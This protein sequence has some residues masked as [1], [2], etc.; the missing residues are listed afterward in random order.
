MTRLSEF[1]RP[2]YQRGHVAH[3]GFL[4][5]I[6]ESQPSGNTVSAHAVFKTSSFTNGDIGRT[7]VVAFGGGGSLY[8]R[9]AFGIRGSDHSDVASRNKLTFT[10]VSSTGVA[11]L[12]LV[13]NVIVTDN[14]YHSICGSYNSATGAFTFLLDMLP[15]DD[16]GWSNR[17][18]TT[19]VLGTAAN[20]FILVGRDTSS[21][22]FLGEIG[23]VGVRNNHYISDW[24]PF[25][26]ANG[27]PKQLD[28]TTWAEWG[29]QPGVFAPDGDLENN[30]GTLGAFRR[31]GAIGP[32]FENRVLRGTKDMP[33]DRGGVVLA[34]AN[35]RYA[36]P[37]VYGNWFP[38]I[39]APGITVEA[40]DTTVDANGFSYKT[41]SYTYVFRATGLPS[42]AGTVRLYQCVCRFENVALSSG[43]GPIL[44]FN[45]QDSSNYWGA[46]VTWNGGNWQLD[47][48]Q[49]IA[50]VYTSRGIAGMTAVNYPTHFIV[51][52]YDAGDNL[53]AFV[54][55]YEV[56]VS[57]NDSGA[58]VQYT[59]VNRPLKTAT[60]VAFRNNTDTLTHS[61]LR[62]LLVM[63]I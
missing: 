42:K 28:T 63:D 9:L 12:T 37:L 22:A 2:W 1:T 23:F 49:V 13:T 52:V 24:S 16:T 19:G 26:Y 58:W 50:G 27:Q 51:S 62:S 25:F 4:G 18:V 41:G 59:V 53:N 21:S 6:K 11:L 61:R 43:W 36:M 17:V 33:Q 40:I 30:L 39:L 38:Q 57:T 3:N 54:S 44:I 47:L 10:V 48:G 34:M 5:Y 20:S 15:A 8:Q 56:D 32:H 14:R 29:A 31:L 60:G 46:F 7:V 45:Y 55:G 35:P